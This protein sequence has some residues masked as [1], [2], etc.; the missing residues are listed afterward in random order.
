MNEIPAVLTFA[1]FWLP[2]TVGFF[3][4][5]VT[6]AVALALTRDIFLR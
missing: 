5:V 1:L 4:I 2:W 6:S 3:V